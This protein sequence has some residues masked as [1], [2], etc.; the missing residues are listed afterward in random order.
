MNLNKTNP[1]LT[2][3]V[4]LSSIYND[5]SKTNTLIFDLGEKIAKNM[6]ELDLSKIYSIKFIGAR[7]K[8]VSCISPCYGDTE[9]K[10]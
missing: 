10:Q 1:K 6:R 3:E 9:K 5:F 8:K 7:R 4:L 2:D